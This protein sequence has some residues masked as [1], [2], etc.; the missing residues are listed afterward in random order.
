MS[1]F[2]AKSFMPSLQLKIIWRQ[3]LVLKRFV[4]FLVALYFK[5][6]GFELT[7]QLENYKIIIFNWKL[8]EI[9]W[10]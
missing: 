4:S 2:I 3:S 8:L 10:N 7:S 5:L 1:I 6:C 9:A